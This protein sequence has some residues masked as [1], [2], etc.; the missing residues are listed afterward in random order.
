MLTKKHIFI[1]AIALILV[2]ESFAQTYTAGDQISLQVSSF[3]LVATNNAPINLTLGT[4]VAGSPVG[5]VTNSD[6][7]VRISSIV[8]G[9][10]HRELT[11][12]ISNGSVPAGTQLTLVS[13]PSTTTNSG[14]V[15]GTVTS[16]PFVLDAIDK[17]LVDNI[18]TCYTGTGY[19]DGYRLTYNW[20]P[21]PTLTDYGLIK[22]TASPVSITV[23]IT[24]TEH[25]SN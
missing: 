25:N 22:S 21:I 12:R 3:S 7:Y 9:G 15:L 6:M 4:T 5:V 20:Q 13:A 1:L 2:D 11:A 17:I 14:G 8:P 18:G 23:V 19:N 16:S 10:T 24:I